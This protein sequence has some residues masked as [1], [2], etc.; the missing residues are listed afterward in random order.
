MIQL[1]I[2]GGS[3]AYWE[4][5]ELIRDINAVEN[6]YEIIAVLDDDKGIIGKNFDGVIVDG[7]LEKAITFSQDVKFIFAIG[8]YKT[9]I[10]R[11]AILKRLNINESRFETLIH[12]SAKIFSTA[13]VGNGCIIHY[14]TIVFNHTKISSFCVIAANCV[15]AVSNYIGRGALLGSGIITTTGVKIGSYSFIGS[16][17]LIG[18][19]IEIEPGAQVGMGSL[20]L[21][22]IK[23]GTFVLG[24]PPKTLDKIEV[25]EEILTDWRNSLT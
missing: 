15:I 7:P 22:N 8:S 16:G 23:A 11:S 19:Y 21:K 12:P 2:L 25:P 3:N 13:T 5:T 10:I 14:G 9:R 17:T 4:I 24:N 18:E 20:I 6:K 1:V